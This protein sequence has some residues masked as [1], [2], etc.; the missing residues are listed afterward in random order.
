VCE[1]YS[2]QGI[3]F[4]EGIFRRFNGRLKMWVHVDDHSI[5]PHSP[6]TETNAKTNLTQMAEL[7]YILTFGSSRPKMKIDEAVLVGSEITAGRSS[8]SF[9]T[10]L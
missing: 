10:S 8:L 4:N 5:R 9:R 2:H 7:A 1:I 6:N 3:F